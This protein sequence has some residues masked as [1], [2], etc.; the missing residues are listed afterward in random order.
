MTNDMVAKIFAILSNF[1]AHV[2]LRQGGICYA[3]ANGSNVDAYNYYNMCEPHRDVIRKYGHLK[4]NFNEFCLNLD[5]VEV[6]SVFFHTE[7]DRAKCQKCLKEIKELSAVRSFAYNLELMNK[8]AGKGNALLALSCLLGIA[9]EKTI[10]LGDS[11]NDSS[12]IQ[13]AG[14]GLAVS[15]AAES[16][17]ALADKI[18][19]SNEEHVISHIVKHYF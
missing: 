9:K 16:L 8:R 18:I 15:N 6:M 14:L 10:G 1:E 4:N 12:I 3:D 19:C 13:A 2:S 7:E 11:E 5:H 17:K